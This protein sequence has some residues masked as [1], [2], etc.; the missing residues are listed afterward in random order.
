MPWSMRSSPPA[1]R[2]LRRV[3]A[4]TF[5]AMD[6]EQKLHRIGQIAFA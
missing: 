6:F 5:V 2:R 3:G 1:V 4:G